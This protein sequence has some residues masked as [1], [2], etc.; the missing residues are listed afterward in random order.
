VA[1]VAYGKGI[2]LLLKTNAAFEEGLKK[3]TGSGVVMAVCQNSMRARKVKVEDLFPFATPV[4]S[5]VA[6]LIR[7]QEAGFAYIRA[8]E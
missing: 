8:G 6:E 7:K 5:G 1:V 3:A 4:D 2:N